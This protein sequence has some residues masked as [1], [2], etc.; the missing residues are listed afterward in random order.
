MNHT[1]LRDFK[2]ETLLLISKLI[3]KRTSKIRETVFLE[4]TH[5]EQ[6]ELDNL[7]EFQTQTLYARSLVLSEQKVN[8]N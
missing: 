5:Q 8:S 2:P 6:T 1:Q 4:R 3:D 7:L